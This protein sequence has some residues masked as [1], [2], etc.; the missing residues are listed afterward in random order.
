MYFL[1]FAKFQILGIGIEVFLKVWYWFSVRIIIGNTQTTTD[2][3]Y[4]HL[5]ILRLKTVLQFIDTRTQSLEITHLEYLTA[6]MEVQSQEFDIGEFISL[7]NGK[8]HILHRD[9]ELI[10]CKSCSDI[11][12]GMSSYIRIYAKTYASC[13]S[14]YAC[15]FIDNLQFRF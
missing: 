8:L 15:Q 10:L 13:F 3:D 4:L 5:D 9:T 14:L 2:I 1:T 11:G 12:M 6:N 7:T